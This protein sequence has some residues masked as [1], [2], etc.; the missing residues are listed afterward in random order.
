M[1]AKNS[2]KLIEGGF[3]GPTLFCIMVRNL[4]QWRKSE[5][6]FFEHEDLPSSLTL[7]KLHS[8]SGNIQL[9][10]DQGHKRGTNARLHHAAQPGTVDKVRQTLL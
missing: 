2:E 7:C 10:A 1:M 8:K 9:K 6:N 4:V 5:R 3:V